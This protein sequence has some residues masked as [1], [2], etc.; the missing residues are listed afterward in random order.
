MRALRKTLAFVRLLLLCVA[1]LSA[2][3]SVVI[4]CDGEVANPRGAT[5]LV[6]YVET[7]ITCCAYARV[8][9][10]AVP[11]HTGAP[12]STRMKDA[13]R[14]LLALFALETAFGVAAC[15][16]ACLRFGAAVEFGM[17]VYP[18]FVDLRPLVWA[19]QGTGSAL[20]T[21]TFGIDVPT[22]VLAG[23]LTLFASEKEQ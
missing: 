23:A 6:G 22:G 13:S 15:V 10:L 16:V 7:I 4:V 9:T 3:V 19:T 11:G 2:V 12:A 17:L 1:V 21:V 18:G 14:I 20:P 5:S 8:I